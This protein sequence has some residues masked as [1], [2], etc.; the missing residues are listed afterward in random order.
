MGD[1]RQKAKERCKADHYFSETDYLDTM[2]KKVIYSLFFLFFAVLLSAIVAVKF[3]G[4]NLNKTV[5]GGLSEIKKISKK[6]VDWQALDTLDTYPISHG[7]WSTLSARHVTP[8]GRVDYRGIWSD[9][10]LFQK[11]LELLSQNPPNKKNWNREQQLAFWINA[12]NAF[13]V[14]LI[15]D[16]Y[17]IKSIEELGG[18][19]PF[20]NSPWDIKFFRLGGI[21]F[22]LNTI[23]H[24]ILRKQFDEPR[25]HFAINCASTSC[26]KLRNE[27][28]T[29]RH[30]EFQLEE[31]T[32]DFLLDETKNIIGKDS[33]K[34]SPI[35]DWFGV[36]FSGYGSLQNFV[37]T[38][39]AGNISP[40]VTIIFMDYDW[41]LN[42]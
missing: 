13:T 36:D 40:D 32:Q 42:E 14:K 8:D 16:N 10:L 15:L 20:V 19:V 30:L 22:D 3:F 4:A 26:P 11:Y 17:P 23:E 29:A 39:Y 6:Q 24:E 2:F 33:L 34:L 41:G 7:D 9:S 25:I 5:L 21:D 28:F 1:K 35:F 38:H 31:Q 12:Y 37:D 27:A 18:D